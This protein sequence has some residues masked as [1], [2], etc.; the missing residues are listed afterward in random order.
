MFSGNV[1]QLFLQAD[2]ISNSLGIV[3]LICS[4]CGTKG[5]LR[6]FFSKFRASLQ[7]IERMK[8]VRLI[9]LLF[10]TIVFLFNC[11]PGRE[12]KLSSNTPDSAFVSLSE[13]FLD[14]YLA[15]RPQTGTYLGLHE[16]DGKLKDYSKNSI[17]TELARLKEYEQKLVS[18]AK[19]SLSPRMNYDYRI[20]L[21]AVRQEIFSMEDLDIY[22]KNPMT[23]AGSLDLNI[24]I[25]RNFAPLEERMKSI[26]AIE[27]KSPSIFAAARENLADSLAKPYIETAILIARGGASFLKNELAEALKQVKNDS[28]QQSF[29]RSNKLAIAELEN[30]ATYLEK[31]KLPKAHN[32]YAIGRENYQKMLLY[33]EMLTIT[34]EEILTMGM[35]E[36]KKEQALFAEVAKKIDPTKKAIDVFEEIK[37][38]HPTAAKLIPDAKKNLEAIRQFV[39]DKNII[40]IPSEVRVNL[41]ETPPFARSTGTASMDTPGPFEKKATEAFY[42]ITP[43]ED[44]WTPKQKEEW[45]SQF[46]YYVTDIISIHEAYPGH[47][48]NFLHLN[49]SGATKIERIFVSY[50]FVEGWAHY[51]EKMMIEEG[52]G[53]TDSITAAKYH[54]AQLD[55]SL[56]RLCRLCVSVKTHCEGMSLADATKFIEDNAYYS[57]KP[58]YQEALRGT[59]DPGYLS[60]T[61]GKLQILK[62]REDYK[63]QEGSNFS[64]QKFHDTFLGSGAPPIELVRE[65][66]IR[67]Q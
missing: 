8:F 23:Y 32:S 7:P 4:R 43:V 65:L 58:A 30:F 19:D 47:Y 55:E 49:A 33:N 12:K 14:G 50:A 56:L 35:E 36:L 13:E 25:Q 1:K 17:E 62:L 22:G 41:Q 66:M 57:Y 15:W 11:T 38:D 52:F 46:S 6:I 59:F 20:L 5:K 40:T 9:A 61:L 53:A 54:L 45:L 60:Y 39:I 21:S 18:F 27:E 37:K 28:L 26:I 2:R 51:T 3:E 34:P 48:V 42:Y 29:S 31:Q 10:F 63:K 16:Y 67:K 24:Y 44:N 64:L